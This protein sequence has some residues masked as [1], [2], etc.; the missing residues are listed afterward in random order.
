M[1]CSMFCQI[2][3]LF[4]GPL[5]IFRQANLHSQPRQ[6]TFLEKVH[7]HLSWVT[8]WMSRVPCHVSHVACQVSHV[9]SHLFSFLFCLDI[10]VKLVGW[11][12]V[13]S[14]ST[15]SS[16]N[17]NM[18]YF[19]SLYFGKKIVLLD[20]KA[21]ITF[22]ILKLSFA[23]VIGRSSWQVDRQDLVYLSKKGGGLRLWHFLVYPILEMASLEWT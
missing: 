14:G 2:F 19:S 16:N 13:I 1:P 11:G 5:N 12:P 23:T 9:A 8:C 6:L 18:L 21:L 17:L 4:G 7:F 10:V 15:P 20:L 3:I 22:L